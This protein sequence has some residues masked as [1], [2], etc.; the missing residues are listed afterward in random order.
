MKLRQIVFV[1]AMTALIVAAARL[2]RQSVE[3]TALAQSQ[4]NSQAA[5]QQTA[6]PAAPQAPANQDQSPLPTTPVLRT[7]SRVV[8]VDVVVT[9]KKGNYV[10]DLKADDFKV[11]EDNK[12]Q[13]VSTFSFGMDPSAPAGSQ[14][15]YMVLFFDNSTMEFGDQA[16]ARSA[17]SK[18]IDANA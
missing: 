14:R 3:I 13:S 16:Q 9:D 18:F 12:Q 5:S 6:P 2:S 10:T 4:Q 17:A 15:H 1:L 8:R 7:E 11:F